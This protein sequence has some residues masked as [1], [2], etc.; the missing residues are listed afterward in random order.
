MNV[1]LKVFTQDKKISYIS[2]DYYPGGHEPQRLNQ[3]C[4]IVCI[5]DKLHS[6]GY[7][8]GDIRLPNLVFGSDGGGY[9]IDFDLA[10]LEGDVYPRLYYHNLSVRHDDAY[11]GM[12]MRK[13]HDRYSLAMIVQQCFPH[14]D[15]IEKIRSSDSLSDVAA[16]LNDA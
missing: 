12:S 6:A 8:H 9:L 14:A 3:F 1:E 16:M 2:Y 15:V 5:L 7:V 13:S 10:R 11:S 4:N